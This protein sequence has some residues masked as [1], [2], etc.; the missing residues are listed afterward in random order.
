MYSFLNVAG[1]F[2]SRL[3]GQIGLRTRFILIGF[4]AS[5]P[6]VL[7]LLNMADQERDR[8]MSAALDRVSLLASVAAEREAQLVE[9][10]RLL[11]MFLAN[12]AEVQ[13]GGEACDALLA[14]H[15]ELYPWLG[16][17]RVSAVD[18][19]GLCADRSDAARPN[20]A[21][22]SYFR[23]VLAGER[24]NVSELVIDRI[25]GEPRIIAAGPVRRGSRTVAVISGGIKLEV[26]AA[27][28][29][30]GQNADG[31]LVAWMVDRDG[32]L[33]A[34]QPP[35]PQLTGQHIGDRPVVRLALRSPRGVAEVDDL[36]GVPRLFA[37]RPLPESDAVMAV[38]LDRASVVGAIDKAAFERLIVMAAIFGASVL[39]GLAG[40]EILI[41][42]PLL[43]LARTARALEKGDLSVRTHRQA[44]GEVGALA[45]A[46]NSMAE[47][48]EDRE[49][50]LQ[51]AKLAA[52]QASSRAEH[53][54]QA[55]TDF[56]ASMSHEIRTP[57]GGIIGYTELIMD[58]ELNPDQRRYAERIE[59]AAAALL[60]VVNDILN[61]SRIE[62]GE[63]ELS[64]RPFSLA[65]L[66]D[67][68]ISIVRT[69]ANRKGIPVRIGLDPALPDW[70][71]G[72]EARLRQVLLNLL[73]NA[74]KFT[75]KGHVSLTVDRI[76]SAN[77]GDKFRFVVTDTGIG[78]A[79][80][81]LDRLFR[82]FSQVHGNGG[83]EYGGTGL[84]L[85]ISKSLVELMG[86]T[87]GLETEEGQGSTFWFEVCLPR[88]DAEAIEPSKEE[89]RRRLVR[90]GRILVADDLPM[91][92]EIAAAMLRS[93]GH[94][95]EV[96]SDGTEAVEEIRRKPYDLVLMDVVMRDMDGIAATRL[97]RQLPAPMSDVP[98]LAI[99]ANVLP[100]QVRTFRQA[101]M[102]G[103]LGK[104][105]LRD[106]LLDAVERH[107]SMGE[108]KQDSGEGSAADAA[109]STDGFDRQTFEE[110]RGL[111]GEERTA[112]WLVS[113]RDQ[114][115]NLLASA[116]DREAD[117]DKLIRIA[118][119]L[120]SHAGSLGF[121]GLSRKCRSLEEACLRGGDFAG[122]LGAAR[123]AA[124][125][126]LQELD[127]LLPG[128]GEL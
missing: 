115:E 42:S 75:A 16:E 111:L 45:G 113:L 76:G 8:A 7:I 97:I 59:A 74:V 18:G 83:S 67:N 28:L 54:N 98:I 2:F 105:F 107:L 68:T 33:I 119:G 55:K 10:A 90:T 106:E 81:K 93:A 23:R 35:L 41:F 24:F 51:E 100:Q 36:E 108:A 63:I 46:L 94:E 39:I 80:D 57:L 87:I 53:A 47:A 96:V 77:A 120:V 124:Q 14:R 65:A 21:D 26:F 70:V 102:N 110:M 122:E 88:A 99:T 19:S 66:V 78:I 64:A 49:K 27:L 123:A 44:V 37:F 117:R 89:G 71:V 56:L 38:G 82:R 121:A 79:R 17:L 40:S 126:A 29:R 91:N 52:E 9:Q 34:R 118:H 92:Q 15:V 12:S 20:L 114:L 103:H 116:A 128:S 43:S 104:P 3:A 30:S 31:D 109:A 25:S 11:L 127:R 13:A 69:F 61:F 4:A 48:I 72:D 60:T 5:L 1:D 6:L 86:G 22:R 58:G 73:N 84:G 95:V 85:A 62:A 50:Q 32:T 125:A 112:R 101:G